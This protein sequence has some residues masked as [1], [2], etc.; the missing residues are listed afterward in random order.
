MKSVTKQ[1]FN[2]IQK[3]QYLLVFISKEY[4]NLIL[5]KNSK[6]HQELKFCISQF[7]K[8][9]EYIRSQ[10]KMSINIIID[11]KNFNFEPL[12]G[13][14]FKLSD[15]KNII[16]NDL[17]DSAPSDSVTFLANSRYPS[18]TSK[19]T[20]CK[21][22]LDSMIREF[23][24]RMGDLKI[25]IT[26]PWPLW[27]IDNYFS[28][29][30][31]D[32]RKFHQ[33][34]FV[35]TL[36]KYWEIIVCEQNNIVCYRNGLVNN[37]NER[38]EIQNT[39]EYLNATCGI[40]LNDTAIYKIDDK[41]VSTFTSIPKRRV[42]IFAKNQISNIICSNYNRYLRIGGRTLS[43]CFCIIISAQCID[44]YSLKQ[45]INFSQSKISN[46]DKILVSEKNMWQHIDDKVIARKNILKLINQIK[47]LTNFELLKSIKCDMSQEN[48]FSLVIQCVSRDSKNAQN[49]FSLDGC[50]YK[51]NSCGNEIS[52]YE[53]NND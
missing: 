40:S 37:F 15:I 4:I 1:I 45:D 53:K 33:S 41:I 22:T 26:V 31:I 29:F 6:V 2:C 46:D 21:T 18:N 14:K 52:C 34:L 11:N 10:K 43:L 12:K 25:S 17:E 44:L 28:L 51:V 48:D 27:V 39:L 9:L 19:V 42:S 36:E 7:E 20:I 24:E 8:G 5:V 49:Q 50:S 3:K 35:V 38:V 47:R 16:K 32:L 23:L 13:T 30:H